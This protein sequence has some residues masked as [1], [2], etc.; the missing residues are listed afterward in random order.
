MHP[1]IPATEEDAS[2]LH[3]TLGATHGARSGTASEIANDYQVMMSAILGTESTGSA[4]REAGARIGQPVATR[5]GT[6]L[7]AAET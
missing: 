6:C 7:A 4:K 1:M 2:G 3:A 5:A